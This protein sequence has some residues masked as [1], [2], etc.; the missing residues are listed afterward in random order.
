MLKHYSSFHF[1]SQPF[2]ILFCI[3][4]NI[5]LNHKIYNVKMVIKLRTKDLM[6]RNK[7][8]VNII[9]PKIRKEFAV[10]FRI[11]RMVLK[12]QR[13]NT[14][15]QPWNYYYSLTISISLMFCW[16]INRHSCLY[17]KVSKK[18]KALLRYFSLTRLWFV[19]EKLPHVLLLS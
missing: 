9:W 16:A 13:E 1:K 10:I 15:S 11:S 17:M 2:I 7:I 6:D 12:R 4:F 5:S 8:K 3:Q 19:R 14:I 18:D